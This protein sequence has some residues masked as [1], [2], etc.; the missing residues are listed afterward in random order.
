MF[1]VFQVLYEIAFTIFRT[2]CTI[3]LIRNWQ[4]LLCGRSGLVTDFKEFI[5]KL[6]VDKLH[7][8]MHSK[9]F[10]SCWTLQRHGL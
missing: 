2:E 4:A 6:T 3:Y 8:C 5:D 1:S 7:A 10:Q 9:S